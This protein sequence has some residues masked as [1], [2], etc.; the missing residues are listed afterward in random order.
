MQERS[1]HQTFI[2]STNTVLTTYLTPSYALGR[3]DAHTQP[4]TWKHDA[5]LRL[6]PLCN[7]PL[8][9]YVYMR[10][11]HGCTRACGKMP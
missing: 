11:E 9:I 5:A 8:Y 7:R 10:V 2:T 1:V 4:K 6:L 3:C